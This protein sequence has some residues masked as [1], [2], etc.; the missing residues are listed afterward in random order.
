VLFK[1]QEIKK[2]CIQVTNATFGLDNL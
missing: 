1:N 2:N